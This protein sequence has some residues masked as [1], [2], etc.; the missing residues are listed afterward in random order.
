MLAPQ[1]LGSQ[2][3]GRKPAAPPASGV[4]SGPLQIQRYSVGGPGD[5]GSFL[6]S[7]VPADSRIRNRQT[8][9]RITFRLPTIRPE[10]VTSTDFLFLHTAKSAHPLPGECPDLSLFRRARPHHNG[11]FIARYLE[12]AYE[13]SAHIGG[14]KRTFEVVRNSL[15]GFVYG[16]RTKIRFVSVEQLGAVIT[17]SGARRVAINCCGAVRSRQ[18][19]SHVPAGV[20]HQIALGCGSEALLNGSAVLEPNNSGDE[21]PCP[22]QLPSATGDSALQDCVSILLSGPGNCS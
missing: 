13:I 6:G 11:Q 5:R 18:L 20:V 21:P 17:R 4:D 16:V 1:S 22:Y 12:F 10:A 15:I 7:I 3:R 9:N 2:S 14:G 19:H 8:R